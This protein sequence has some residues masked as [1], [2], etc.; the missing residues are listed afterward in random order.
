MLVSV[1]F[2][3]TPLDRIDDHQSLNLSV[4]LDGKRLVAQ[5]SRELRPLVLPVPVSMLF[6]LRHDEG[7]PV[8]LVIVQM[9]LK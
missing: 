3:A 8:D 5:L 7:V 2:D 9:S 6:A 1:L 4:A